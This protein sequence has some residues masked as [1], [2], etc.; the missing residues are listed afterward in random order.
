SVPADGA[1]AVGDQR[2]LVELHPP[3]HV[4]TVAE[5]DVGA[6]VDGGVGKG[7]LVSP[8]LAEEV[9]VPGPDVRTVHTLGPGLHLDDDQIRVRGRPPYQRGRGRDVVEVGPGAVHREAEY[10]DAN[11]LR[12]D[13]RDLVAP[14]GGLHAGTPERGTCGGEPGRAHVGAVVVGQ[15]QYAEPA[16]VQPRRV[17]R[18]QVELVTVR[19]AGRRRRRAAR[20]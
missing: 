20:T 5:Y 9:L 12:G 11:A 14:P 10:G 4:W 3:H 19:I 6:R 8:V 7:D 16:V 2:S 15:V 17:R 13:V 1:E 18:G